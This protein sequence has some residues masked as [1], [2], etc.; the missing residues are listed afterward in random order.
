MKKT[1]KKASNFRVGIGL[2]VVA[3]VA[4]ASIAFNIPDEEKTTDPLASME[5][6]EEEII[7][8]ETRNWNNLGSEAEPEA[9]ASGLLSV[10]IYPHDGDPGTTYAE[11]TSATLESA[12]YC[13]ANADAQEIHPPHTDTFDIV[14]R[15]RVN[16]TNCYDYVNDQFMDT[17]V[18]VNITSSDLSISET[19]A[20]NVVSHNS[21]TE[22][23]IYI[24]AYLNNGGAGYSIDRDE[25]AEI[26]QL[27]L[28]AYY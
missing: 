8:A 2:A 15:V 24:N 16:K 12:A 20:T 11:N 27:E 21:S 13:Y 28:F 4:I 10:Y 3:M 5:D 9:G 14:V 18:R 22:G 25:T 7:S 17:W 23:Y 19:T 1:E 26:S 6:V